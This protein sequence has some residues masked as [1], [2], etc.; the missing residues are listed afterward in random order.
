MPIASW[1]VSLNPNLEADSFKFKI[2][3]TR[4]KS[5][6][7]IG[8]A[9]VRRRTTRGV[10]TA[11]GSIIILFSEYATFRTFFDTTINGGTDPFTII[12]PITRV[13]ATF[14]FVDTPEIRPLGPNIEISMS[15]EEIP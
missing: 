8:P 4:I 15:W 6:F 5:Q 11:N 9:K 7:D 3:E 2:G 1:P 13:T 10:D 14:R 12:H